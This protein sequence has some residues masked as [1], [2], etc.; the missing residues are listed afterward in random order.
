[1]LLAHEL[2][3]QG[4]AFRQDLEKDLAAK[5]ES[6]QAHKK[7]L[8]AAK[9]LVEENGAACKTVEEQIDKVHQDFM[10]Y[11][12]RKL[13]EWNKLVTGTQRAVNVYKDL[14]E[15]I[16]KESETPRNAPIVDFMEWLANE[17][18]TISD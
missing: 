17:L 3:H 5:D 2:Q 15:S 11:Q 14:I 10:G 4:H 16:G 8:E 7:E 1:M 18:A 13:E 6:I 12:K 9:K